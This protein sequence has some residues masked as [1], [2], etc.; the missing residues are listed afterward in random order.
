MTVR[1]SS[2]TGQLRPDILRLAVETCPSG[3]IVT[4]ADGGI[5]LVNREIERLFG[6]DRDDLLGRSIDLL[7]PE[8]LRSIHTQHRRAFSQ[9]PAARH[10]GA[11]REFNGRRKDGSEVPIE[12][13]LNPV[14]R[15]R[16]DGGLRR[17][18]YQRAQAPRTDAG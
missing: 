13:G 2:A 16:D 18:R 5:L 11:G 14:R 15:R 10:F 7:L 17:G 12:V 8:R 4:G 3:V 9:Q 6:Y 1:P